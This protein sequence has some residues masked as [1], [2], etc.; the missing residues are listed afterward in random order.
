[1]HDE[2]KPVIFPLLSEMI[3]RQNWKKSFSETKAHKINR[4][5]TAGDKINH[6]CIRNNKVKTI[7]DIDP[8]KN[9]WGA[10]NVIY[11]KLQQG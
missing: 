3:T 1:M 6:K 11:C 8:P 2:Y 10:C 9:K 5:S 7:L 4:P